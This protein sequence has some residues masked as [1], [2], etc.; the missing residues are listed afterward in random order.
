MTTGLGALLNGAA[1][2]F[3]EHGVR[4][5]SADRPLDFRLQTYPE[6]VR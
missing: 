2:R 5:G 3:P 6:L 1:A 4:N